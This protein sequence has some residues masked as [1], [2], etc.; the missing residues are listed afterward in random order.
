M[1]VGTS[2]LETN[3]LVDRQKKAAE[4]LAQ[5]LLG[6]NGRRSS[7][8]PSGP[9]A[10]GLGG[11]FASRVGVSK[12][13][14]SLPRNNNN[15]RAPRPGG[16]LNRIRSDLGDRPSRPSSTRPEVGSRSNSGIVNG[17]GGMSIRGAASSTPLVIV[18]QNFAPGT[19][20]ADIES[21]MNK[22][23]GDLTSCRLVAST[24]T[25]IAEMMFA[26]PTGADNVIEQFNGKKV[27]YTT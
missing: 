12:R 10:A 3:Q 13:N 19:T 9:K 4:N 26:D 24:P 8:P 23:G 27:G 1:R 16:P 14:S 18:A 20:A 25:V 22:V 7:A 17:S 2:D 11:S 21:V 15:P 6:S 5:K